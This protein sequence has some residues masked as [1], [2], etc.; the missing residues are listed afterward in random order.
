MPDPNMLPSPLIVPLQLIL[1]YVQ[2][3]PGRPC[4]ARMRPTRIETAEQ[5]DLRSK[6]PTGQLTAVSG[7]LGALARSPACKNPA[8]CRRTFAL[9]LATV[10]LNWRYQ[11]KHRTQASF[12]PREAF[13]FP[14]LQAL[15]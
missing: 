3:T 5:S 8:K 6:C 7:R 15:S 12:F 11:I 14:S 2:G 4:Q 1:P 13:F 10:A 9:P